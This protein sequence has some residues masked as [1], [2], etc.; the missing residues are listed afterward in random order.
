VTVRKFLAGYEMPR[1]PR[2]DIPP[3]SAA[4]RLRERS[5]KHYLD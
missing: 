2:C 4:A 3:E 5:A 1:Q